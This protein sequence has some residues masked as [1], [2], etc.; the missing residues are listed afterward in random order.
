[1]P[2][3]PS[4]LRQPPPLLLLL[5]LL[6]VLLLGPLGGG[7]DG[8]RAAARR[9]GSAS[10]H[11]RPDEAEL[12]RIGTEALNQ[13]QLEDALASF[14]AAASASATGGRPSTRV[15]RAIALQWL[16]RYEEAVA[17]LDGALALPQITAAEKKHSL[18]NKGVTLRALER[19]V[20]AVE[21]LQASVALQPDLADG[22]HH[23]CA[24]HFEARDPASDVVGTQTDEHRAHLKLAIRS[25][26]TAINLGRDKFTGGDPDDGFSA[27]H[28]TKGLILDVLQRRAEAVHSTETALNLSPAHRPLATVEQQLRSRATVLDAHG[29]LHKVWPSAAGGSGP[30]SQVSLLSQ[31]FPFLPMYVA[32]LTSAESTLEMNAGLIEVLRAM[33]AQDPQGSQLSNVGGWQSNKDV[34]FLE[35]D[36]AAVAALH[37]HIVRQV[38]SFLAELGLPDGVSGEI[39]MEPWVT[40]REA[41][42]NVNGMGHRNYEHAHSTATFAGCYYVSSGFGEDTSAEYTGLRLH[43]RAAD[44]AAS[45]GVSPQVDPVQYWTTGALG[46]T[47]TLALW[48]GD[49]T[50]NLS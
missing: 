13:N 32:Q 46:A 50:R 18:Y 23:I 42:A 5:S 20:E 14:D 48:P 49:I 10:S 34:N 17:A 9:K 36:A 24:A 7:V 39:Q 33:V 31:A 45:A 30:K 28:E 37:I 22:H 11:R 47:G 44:P 4:R 16:G 43:S 41:W 35:E 29:V 8:R 3:A 19:P 40:I 38:S 26:D 6:L 12:Y 1:M 2:H 27:A 25:C 21:S 15:N